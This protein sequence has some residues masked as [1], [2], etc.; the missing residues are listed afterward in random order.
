MIKPLVETAKHSYL[1]RLLGPAHV[2]AVGLHHVASENVD[3]Y[4][5]YWF[6]PYYDIVVEHD[7]GILMS[8]LPFQCSLSLHFVFPHLFYCFFRLPF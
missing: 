8:L 2:L 6:Y 5:G 7:D 1:S 3:Y 4:D